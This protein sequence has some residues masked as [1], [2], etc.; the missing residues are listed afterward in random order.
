MNERY[1]ENRELQEILDGRTDGEYSQQK[2]AASPDNHLSPF[3]LEN[4]LVACNNSGVQH[5]D[6]N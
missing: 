1:G 5:C 3:F 2:A 4:C 6:G